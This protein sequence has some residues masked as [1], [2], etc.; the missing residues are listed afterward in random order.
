MKTRYLLLTVPALLTAFVAHASGT[1]AGGHNAQAIG[2]PGVAAKVTRTINVDMTDDMR[3][4][5]AKQKRTRRDAYGSLP[6][7]TASVKHEMVLGSERSSR[8]R[9]RTDEK[10]SRDGA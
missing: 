4:S 5:A 8:R 2:S 6:R 1:H 10:K 3:F 9:R 7:T